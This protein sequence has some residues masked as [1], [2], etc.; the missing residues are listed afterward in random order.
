MRFEETTLA[1][2]FVIEIDRTA[3]ERGSFARTF[4]REAFLDHG[5]DPHVEQASVSSN[6]RRGT[7]RGLHCQNPPSGQIPP[8]GQNPPP[9]EAKLI[10]CAG[11]ALLD[12]IVDLR[13]GSATHGDWIGIELTAASGR[14]VYAPAG[15][16][17][18]FQTL[19][20]DTEVVYMT[21][22]PHDPERET[23]VRWD[24]PAFG[25]DWPLVP[26]VMSVRDRA[27]PDY[28][29]AV[30]GTTRREPA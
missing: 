13:P 24:D 20:D 8:S 25:I 21:S 2:V 30:V 27:W 19:E 9:G 10:R 23:G 16:A 15:T 22:A 12:V 18:G 4:C 29:A 26:T 7:L 6:A 14:S 28:R 5:L 11:G 17:H 3:D 1:G